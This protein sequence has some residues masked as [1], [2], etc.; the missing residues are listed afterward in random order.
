MLTSLGLPTHSLLT[1]DSWA[2]NTL[3]AHQSRAPTHPPVSRS[4]HTLTA[5]Q[6]WAPNTLTA[7]QSWAPTHPPV[8]RS[9]HTPCSLVLGSQHSL[10]S[11]VLGS[12]HSHCSPV[13]GSHTLHAHQY[14]APTHSPVSRPQHTPCV[15][16]WQHADLCEGSQ[17]QP[18][19]LKPG[20]QHD[21]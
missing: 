11:P 9:Q 2:L 10:C 12:Q 19:L 7:H 6:S 3:H 18:C 17:L 16:V 14:R 1:S 13:L 20:F 15:G 4:Q 8:S 5:H 21:S